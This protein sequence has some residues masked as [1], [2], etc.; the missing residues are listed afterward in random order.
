[1]KKTVLI[2]VPALLLSGCGDP[3]FHYQ[4]GDESKNITLRIPKNYINYFPGVKYEKDGPVVIRFSYPQLEPL[5]KA[6]PE[7][8]KVTVSI[9][10]LSSLELTTQETRN[11]YC[12]TDKKWKLLQAAGIHG[13]FY[14]F[15][16]KSPGSASADITYKPIKKT[17]GLYCITCV[18]NA[19]CEIHAVSSQGIS[20]SAFYTE[21][22][23]PDKWHSIYMAV[24]KI[25]SK[26]TASS[27][28]I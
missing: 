18:E 27:K 14:K 21:D 12:E 15:I 7:E 1:M 22:L 17:L 26:F 8:Q 6:L 11:P 5:T 25:L 4:N 9:S 10:H 28:G 20:Y 13:E 24:D 3:E 16:G 2:L 19:N 23:M